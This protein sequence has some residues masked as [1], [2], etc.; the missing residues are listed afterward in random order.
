MNEKLALIVEFS[1]FSVRRIDQWGGQ[2]TVFSSPDLRECLAEASK[3][4]GY[5][6]VLPISGPNTAL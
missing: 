2:S 6:L 1:F 3:I 4:L 5:P